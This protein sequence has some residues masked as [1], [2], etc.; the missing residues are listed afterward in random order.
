MHAMS[1]LWIVIIT[2]WFVV[3]ASARAGEEVR[4]D[5][6]R[7]PNIV[8]IFM[9]DLGYADI[10]PFGATKYRTPNLTVLA[11]Q[12]RRFTDFVVSS[13]VCSASRAALM[14]GCY[15][16]RVGIS[17]A[18]MPKSNIGLNPDETTIAE[19]CK[20]RGYATACYGKWHLGHHPKFLPT[21]QGFD[22]FYGIPYSNDMWPLNPKSVAARDKDPKA[23]IDWPGLPMIKA[24]QKKGVRVVNDDMSVDDQKQMTGEFTRRA[25]GFIEKNADSPFFVYLPHPMV[26][27]PLHCSDEFLGKSGAGLFGDVVTEI[28]WSVGQIMA[29]IES[30]GQT[31]N[32]L[33]IFTSDNGPWLSYGDHCGSAGGLREGKGTM[34]EGG[35]RE[36]T[37]M[38]WLGKIPPGTETD[39]LCST[40][41]LLPTIAAIIGADLP[42]KKIDGKDIR[43]IL[44]GNSNVSPHESFWGYYGNNELQIIRDDRFKLVFPHRYQ[45]LKGHPGGFG[46]RP[47]PY[48]QTEATFALYDLQADPGE[49]KDVS[50]QHPDVVIRLQKAAE[51]ARK[52]LGDGL[53]QVNASE[54]RA[55]GKFESGDE[56]LPLLW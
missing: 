55:P 16:S 8:L 48:Q 36:P 32:T 9:D 29:A 35:Y 49:T 39:A 3:D 26:H 30:I 24:D 14:T 51:Q 33:V 54:A 15:H 37:I 46:G 43:D 10:T 34:F 44:F 2:A 7:P 20:S 42:S 31:D 50:D 25:V 47:I 6:E 5:Q 17:G 21:A 38:R 23:A 13:A 45:T 28:D 1:R 12:G 11:T 4:T 40:I 56:E 27:V 41:D 53:K 52:E 22:E 19:I 18:L